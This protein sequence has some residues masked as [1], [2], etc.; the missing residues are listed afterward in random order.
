M[1]P[2]RVISWKLTG[3]EASFSPEATSGRHLEISSDRLPPPPQPIK[4]T[5]HH[6]SLTSVEANNFIWSTVR[7]PV[8]STQRSV[9][10]FLSCISWL[11]PTWPKCLLP[12]DFKLNLYCQLR[13]TCN[14]SFLQR[15]SHKTHTYCDFHSVPLPNYTVATVLKTMCWY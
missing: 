15:A 11:K 4:F 1:W 8:T 5:E 10:V 3:Y 6:H 14:F 13:V 12:C 2:V 7:P 9:R